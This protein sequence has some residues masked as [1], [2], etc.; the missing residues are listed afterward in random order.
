M[1]EFSLGALF[2]EPLQRIKV[3][4][5]GALPVEGLTEIY[6]RLLERD[7]CDVVAFEPDVALCEKLN[8][9]GDGSFKYFPSDRQSV[10]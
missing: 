1:I 3:V 2:D 4:D 10:G 6:H 7:L 5:V 8:A 9:Q